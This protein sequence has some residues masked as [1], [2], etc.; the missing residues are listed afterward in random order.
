MLIKINSNDKS[1]ERREHRMATRNNQ[2]ENE[3]SDEGMLKREKIRHAFHAIVIDHH[4]LATAID[5]K[6]SKKVFFYIFV[7]LSIFCI[8]NVKRDKNSKKASLNTS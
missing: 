6:W 5:E 1:S 7:H 2:L 4:R 8:F 3:A